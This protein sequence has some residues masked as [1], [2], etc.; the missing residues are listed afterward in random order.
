MKAKNIEQRIDEIAPLGA[1][2][3][4]AEVARKYRGRVLNLFLDTVESIAILKDAG[5]VKRVAEVADKYAGDIKKMKSAM[6]DIRREAKS[7][8]AFGFFNTANIDVVNAMIE[9]YL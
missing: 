9:K 2:E 7:L 8:Y 1:I 6:K 4:V 3:K 5:A